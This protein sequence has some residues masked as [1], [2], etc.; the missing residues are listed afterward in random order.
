MTTK[1][2][3]NSVVMKVK[4]E[5][6]ERIKDSIGLME[7]KTVEATDNLGEGQE[8]CVGKE[9]V[10]KDIDIKLD[11]DIET[12]EQLSVRPLACSPRRLAW[13]QAAVHS[14]VAATEARMA[15]RYALLER[16]MGRER[17]EVVQVVRELRAAKAAEILLLVASRP[18][19]S[20][21]TGIP[22]AQPSSMAASSTSSSSPSS[23]SS[24]GSNL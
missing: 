14:R 23:A 8:S 4:E 12:S 17:E 15:A 16:R 21:T 19:T 11:E 24:A 22:A 10:P 2:E 5:L 9:P 20:S 1:C 18:V 13:L 7:V 3:R 6:S